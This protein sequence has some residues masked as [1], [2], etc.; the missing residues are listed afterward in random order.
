MSAARFAR[1]EMAPRTA[2]IVVPAIE[3]SRDR[4]RIAGA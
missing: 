3:A 1:T 4:K 2:A